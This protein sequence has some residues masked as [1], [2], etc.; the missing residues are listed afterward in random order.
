MF[1]NEGWTLCAI[2]KL[3]VRT[4]NMEVNGHNICQEMILRMDLPLPNPKYR[5]HFLAPDESRQHINTHSISFE[6]L[7][8]FMPDKKQ[9][10]MR[11]NNSSNQRNLIKASHLL[12]QR[13]GKLW[14][15][16]HVVRYVS[17]VHIMQLERIR[18]LLKT[19]WKNWQ[20][21]W[22]MGMSASTQSII[23]LISM[24]RYNW[25]VA[26]I[27]SLNTTT[28]NIV[29][30]ERRL[31]LRIFV[32]YDTRRKILFNQNKSVTSVMLA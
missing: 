14:I 30:R 19:N 20:N 26:I 13:F 27:L 28:Q 1:V 22:R 2:T 4:Q 18:D 21:I 25:D 8:Q 12:L 15:A 32:Q 23:M 7:E 10:Q 17:S 16:I 24:W 9:T 11:M 5:E 6:S 31:S 29:S 3:K